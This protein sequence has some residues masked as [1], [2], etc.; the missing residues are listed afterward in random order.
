[1]RNVAICLSLACILSACASKPGTS[2][3]HTVPV[4]TAAMS[5]ATATLQG[6]ITRKSSEATEDERDALRTSLSAME[7]FCTLRLSSMESDSKDKAKNAFWLSVAGAISGAV[8]APA[9]TAGNAAGN[10]TAIAAFSGFSGA[11]NFMSQS[12]TSSGNS[13]S[14]DATTRN[15]I[16]T[17]IWQQ[18]NI[19]FDE[20][21]TIGERLTA[22]DKARAACVFY[23]IQVPST[24]QAPSN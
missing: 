15:A 12:L 6:A 16:V 1:M 22:V 2:L 5:K 19:A 3:S 8:I 10:S 7:Q 21:K 11:T 14:A 17:S 4:N 18:L 20:Q 24:T 9:L 13:G 23:S